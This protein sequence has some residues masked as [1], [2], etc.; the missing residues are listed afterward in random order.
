MALKV[1]RGQLA[2]WAPWRWSWRPRPSGHGLA[3]EGQS[4]A[5]LEVEVYLWE[6]SPLAGIYLQL[7]ALVGGWA[8]LGPE[9]QSVRHDATLYKS[10]LWHLKVPCHASIARPNAGSHT[11][12][13]NLAATV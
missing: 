13:V 2:K 1:L 3:W 12:D 9:R 4:A 10:Y 8:G 5:G 6:V 11:V 7:W